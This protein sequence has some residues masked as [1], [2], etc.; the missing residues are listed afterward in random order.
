MK[1][2]AEKL[3]ALQEPGRLWSHA[4]LSRYAACPY[5]FYGRYVLGIT[6]P[7]SPALVFGRLVHALAS[8]L[9]QTPADARPPSLFSWLVA[10]R[11]AD[12]DQALVPGSDDARVIAW[13]EA[14][15]RAVTPTTPALAE[16]VWLQPLPAAPGPR[17]LFPDLQPWESALTAQ[18]PY[19]RFR[20][21]D[22]L[23]AAGVDAVEAR[24]DVVW[25]DGM[26]LVIRDWKTSRAPYGDPTRLIPRYRDQLALYGAVARRRF[27]VLPLRFDLHVLSADAVVPV[28]LTPADLDAA[29]QQIFRTAQAIRAAARASAAGVAG[30]AGFPKEPGDACRFCVLARPTPETPAP[31]CPEGAVHRH[32]QGW[33]RWDAV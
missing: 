31:L 23:R 27:P 8:R 21:E 7:P 3:R 28:P 11:L 4:S 25:R 12:P 9:V 18:V 32:A 19:A 24:P 17:P 33:D 1:P 16:A 30:A 14:A 6:D 10:A 26:H 20:V 2:P 29:T 22:A 15:A 13:A 5:S